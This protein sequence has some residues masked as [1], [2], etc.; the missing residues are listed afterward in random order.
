VGIE[1]IDIAHRDHSG[2]ILKNS[3]AIAE[4]GFALIARA[5]IDF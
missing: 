3:A 2:L 4:A 5:G 1:F